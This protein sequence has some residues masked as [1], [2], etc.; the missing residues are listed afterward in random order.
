MAVKPGLSFFK[1]K[2]FVTTCF[3]VQIINS[4]SC[5]KNS[6]RLVMLDQG[7][8]FDCDEDLHF[9]FHKYRELI[10]EYSIV[11]V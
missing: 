4:S 10:L 7:S 8:H 1:A 3:A 9:E 2:F 5:A 11:D 6:L